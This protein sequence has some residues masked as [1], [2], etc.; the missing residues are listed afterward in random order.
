[1]I[2]KSHVI[3]IFTALTFL[4]PA[5]PALADNPPNMERVLVLDPNQEQYL[6]GPYLEYLEDPGRKL[7]I[8]DVSS[9]EMSS[10]FVRNTGKLMMF[11][12]SSSSHWLRFTVVAPKGSDPK[13]KWL[14]EYG[15]QRDFERGEL[16]IPAADGGWIQESIGRILPDGVDREPRRPSVID[17]PAGLSRPVTIYIRVQSGGIMILPLIIC[18]E[19]QYRQII[20]RGNVLAGLYYGVII[21]MVLYNL[22]L[23]VSLRELN[24]LYY[25]IYASSLVFLF[26]IVDG[27]LYT[28]FGA[29][30]GTARLLVHLSFHLCMFSSMLFG[31]T[32]LVTRQ[33]APRLDKVLTVIMGVS[34]VSIVCAPFIN[35]FWREAL[36]NFE[37]LVAP[38]IFIAAGAVCLRQGYRPARFFLIAF[39]ALAAGTVVAGLTFYGVLPYSIPTIFASRIGSAIEVILLQL[40]LA[41][42][43]NV[44]QAERDRI[45]QSLLLASEVQKNLLP[46]SEPKI[47]GLDIA[48]RSRYCDETGGDH[49]D[50]IYP[51]HSENG[52]IGL[53]VSDVSGHGISSA[54]LMA[55]ARAFL[56]QRSAMPGS[57][58]DVITDVNRQISL[59]VEET[60]QFLTLFFCTIDT[61]DMIVR[62]VNAGHEPAMVY[63]TASDSFEELAGNGLVLGVMEDFEYEEFSQRVLPGQ[64]I[65]IGTDGIWECHNDNDEMFGKDRL[66]QVIRDNSG[67]PA[68]HI[69]DAVIKEV[70]NFSR[71]REIEDDVTLVVVKIAS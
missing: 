58:A 18:T 45:R 1:M 33:H 15:S 39:F 3:L 21:S 31:K 53:V 32:F 67:K 55:T 41:D 27:G 8:N 19:G 30:P 71:P 54:L 35:Q 40:A 28:C 44:I 42:R 7:T 4:L 2:Y 61:G 46:L 60:G 16:Y 47:T 12:I 49:F 43:I 57:I 5:S 48:G 26:F 56:R 13:H 65:L 14:L 69:V 50:Y 6:I 10:R 63:H 29:T 17:P 62:W 34:F 9:P 64:V 68:G 23:L 52:R 59:D 51:G 70:E 36:L 38:P 11:H 66:R 22:I 25:V 37:S 24:R 20:W